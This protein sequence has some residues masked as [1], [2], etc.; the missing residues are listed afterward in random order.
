MLV[1]ILGAFV[2]LGI[3][4]FIHELG[5]LLMGMLVGAKA[6]VFSLGYGKGVWK[7]EWNGTTYQITAIPLGGFVQFYGH[8]YAADLTH[9]GGELMA[10]RPAARALALLWIEFGLSPEDD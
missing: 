1:K 6:K 8:D 7:K 4:I 2:L 9:S 5:H 10:F 3:C